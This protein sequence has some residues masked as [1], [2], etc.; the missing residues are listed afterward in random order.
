MTVSHDFISALPWKGLAKGLSI[1]L[2]SAAFLAGCGEQANTGAALNETEQKY[3]K[4]VTLSGTVSD[5]KGPVTKGRILA[6]D[7][8]G[9]IISS[10]TLENTN[11]Y[12]L[13]I[14][15]G[16][17]LPILLQVHTE[18]EPQTGKP[19][20]LAVAEATM[21]NYNINPLTT[22]IAEKAKSMGGYT[23]K[24]LMAAAVL[25][26]SVPDEDKTSSGFRGDP[27]KN[28]GGWH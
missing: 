10:A 11:R 9:N 21:T 23:R 15:A 13:V 7:E 19:L 26:T 25:S 27:T 5:Q 14:P 12:S 16:T 18:A 3:E 4:E 20:T 6:T 28:Y 2:V 8:K 24:N 22:A 1:L 17:L